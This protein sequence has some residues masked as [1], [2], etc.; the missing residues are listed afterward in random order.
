MK[1]IFKFF[2][3]GCYWVCFISVLSAQTISDLSTCLDSGIVDLIKANGT[4]AS[5]GLSVRAKLVN[6]TKE[7]VYIDVSLKKPLYLLNSGAGQS[8]IAS[9]V[10][11]GSGEYTTD[12]KRRFIIIDEADTIDIGFIAYCADFDKENPS[13]E[14]SFAVNKLPDKLKIVME[15]IRLFSNK[16]PNTDFTKAAQLAIWLKF[17]IKTEEIQT[18]FPYD[19]ED[20]LLALKFIE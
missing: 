19:S 13:S 18:K 9:Q 20:Y 3:I 1:I 6:R 10:Y 11:I 4:G 2:L 5:S 15:K 12:G 14:E 17:G 16:N 8:M 7:K